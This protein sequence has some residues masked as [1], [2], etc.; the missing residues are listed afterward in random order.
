M[1]FSKS[2]NDLGQNF[3]YKNFDFK[4]TRYESISNYMQI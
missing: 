1:K 2:M 4:D 3:M